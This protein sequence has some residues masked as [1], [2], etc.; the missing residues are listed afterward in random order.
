MAQDDPIVLENP[1]VTFDGDGQ[2]ATL[3]ATVPP[4]VPAGTYTLQITSN[5]ETQTVDGTVLVLN[6][7]ATLTGIDPK[8]IDVPAGTRQTPQLTLQGTWLPGATAWA[9]RVVDRDRELFQLDPL[10]PQAGPPWTVTLPPEAVDENATLTVYVTNPDPADPPGEGQTLTVAAS[11]SGGVTIT[12]MGPAPTGTSF[13]QARL[14]S[15][16]RALGGDAA[17][18]RAKRALLEALSSGDN[19]EAV[20]ERCRP[21]LASVGASDEA[22]AG[23]LPALLASR[24]SA[25]AMQSAVETTLQRFQRTRTERRRAQGAR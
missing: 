8:E 25:E 5:G 15:D 2:Q 14:P 1:K 6:V 4:T 18:D 9:T 22:I 10:A 16:I 24:A 12:V 3:T 20:E 23:V 21:I 7:A 17:I 11:A 19:R 13:A